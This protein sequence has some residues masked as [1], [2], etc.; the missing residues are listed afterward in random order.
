MLIEGAF[1]EYLNIPPVQK[2]E[3]RKDAQKRPR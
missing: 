2:F 3:V 1:M